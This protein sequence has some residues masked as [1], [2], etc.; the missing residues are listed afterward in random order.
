MVNRTGSPLSGNKVGLVLPQSYKMQLS[1]EKWIPFGR[2][3]IRMQAQGQLKRAPFA[4]KEGEQARKER[5]RAVGRCSGGV[6]MA[7]PWEHNV[8]LRIYSIQR[9]PPAVLPRPCPQYDLSQLSAAHSIGRLNS[10]HVYFQGF[11]THLKKF[12]VFFSNLLP[13]RLCNMHLRS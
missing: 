6:C 11:F 4:R 12:C 10:V 1:S 13:S 8:T 5:E 3:Q 7:Q 9:L 2:E